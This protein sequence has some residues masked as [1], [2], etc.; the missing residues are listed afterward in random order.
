MGISMQT[1]IK[2]IIAIL[3]TASLSW[4]E[5]TV[6]V[7]GQPTVAA[8]SNI[9][10]AQVEFANG[11]ATEQ[12]IVVIYDHTNSDAL[13]ARTSSTAAANGVV[14]ATFTTNPAL[15]SG[16]EY[17]IGIVAG[18]YGID[19]L[20]APTTSYLYYSSTNGTLSTP[21][22]PFDGA[23]VASA[24]RFNITIRN[25]S[26]TVLLG[27]LDGTSTRSDLNYVDTHVSTNEVY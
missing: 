15:V 25:S 12:F 22:N 27:Q 6:I 13:V 24:S 20:Y 3:L 1:L 23:W 21:V 26:G 9:Y 19:L 2:A 8:T 5:S 10:D 17:Y 16:H 7:V 14:T 11:T 18:G 4:A